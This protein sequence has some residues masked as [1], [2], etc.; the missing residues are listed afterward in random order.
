MKNIILKE[1]AKQLLE[2]HVIRMIKIEL[3]KAGRH[4][5]KNG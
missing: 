3:L 5:V 1:A 2:P 4:Y